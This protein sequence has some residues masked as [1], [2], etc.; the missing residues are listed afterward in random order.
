[1]AGASTRGRRARLRTCGYLPV[2][3]Y[4]QV[5][6]SAPDPGSEDVLPKLRDAST[7][8]GYFDD[9]ESLMRQLGAFGK[10]AVVHAEPDLWGYLQRED[11]DAAKMAVTVKS[12]GAPSVA[13]FDDTAAGFAQALVHVRDLYAPNVLLGFHVSAWATGKDL[14]LNSADPV[15]TAAKIGAFYRSLGVEFDLLFL[16]ASDRDAAWYETQTGKKDHWWDGADFERFRS[17]VAAAVRDMGKCAVIWQVP[18]G[19]TLYRSV[20]NSWGHYQDNR[21]QYWLGD[22]ARMQQLADAGVVALLFGAGADGCTMY[23]DEMQDGITNPS[24][25]DSNDATAQYADDD[26]GHLRLRAT[27]YYQTGAIPLPVSP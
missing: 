16:D 18:V 5:V 25:I 20:D 21:A 13:G 24:P 14:I 12:S 1:L 11:S 6:A 4:Y 3:T 10:T 17:F 2:F 7:M 8:R 26:G 23:T 15:D 22:R 27:E 19:N 9:W